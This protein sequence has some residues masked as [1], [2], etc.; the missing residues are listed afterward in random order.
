MVVKYVT[1]LQPQE[2]FLFTAGHVIDYFYFTSS[3]LVSPLQ[4]QMFCSTTWRPSCGTAPHTSPRRLQLSARGSGHSV[5]PQICV[6][7]SVVL[8]GAHRRVRTHD[9][10]SLCDLLETFGG[11][12]EKFR[13]AQ[14]SRENKF[15]NF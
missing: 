8:F 3:S 1:V 4:P 12:R 9:S 2:T 6:K 15:G 11:I 13:V 10:E 14:H 7:A 5:P